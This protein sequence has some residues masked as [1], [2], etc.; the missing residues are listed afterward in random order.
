VLAV[1][2]DVVV[3]SAG[4]PTD[5]FGLTPR[6]IQVVRLIAIGLRNA[7]IGS[8][9]GVSVHT[10]LRHTERVLRKLGVHSRAAVAGALHER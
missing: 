1:W 10:T 6:E 9:L 7:E 5:R 2:R 8:A 4:L 3:T